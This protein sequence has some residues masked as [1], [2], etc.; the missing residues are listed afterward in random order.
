MSLACLQAKITA[1]TNLQQTAAVP[2]KAYCTTASLQVVVSCH[3][4]P[5]LGFPLPSY[6]IPGVQSSSDLD[7]PRCLWTAPQKNPFISLERSRHRTP[8][9]SVKAPVGSVSTTAS[10]CREPIRCQADLRDCHK[11]SDRCDDGCGHDPL[12]LRPVNEFMLKLCRIVALRIT[13]LLF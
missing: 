6:C 9:S 5:N 12:N 3:G 4:C 10:P 13:Y 11:S 7:R 2:I 1:R 8:G